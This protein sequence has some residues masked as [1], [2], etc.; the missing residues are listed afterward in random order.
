VD[1]MY[2]GLGWTWRSVPGWVFDSKLGYAGGPESWQYRAGVQFRLSEPQRVWLGVSVHDETVSRTTIGSRRS[3]SFDALLFGIDPLDYYRE[4]GYSLSLSTK[5]IDFTRL[6]LGFHDEHQTSLPVTE[7]YVMFPGHRTIRDS[8]GAIVSDTSSATLPNPPIADGQMRS[9][10]ATLSV[11]SRSFMRQKGVDYLLRSPTWTRVTLSGE[12]STPSLVA[13]DFDFGRYSLTVE[14]RQR[15]WAWGFATVTASGAITTGTVPPQRYYA[16]DFSS[17]ALALRGGGIRSLSDSNF[18]ATRAA[19]VTLRQ[20]FGRV[21]MRTGLPLLKA[22]PFTLSLLGGAY[23]TELAAPPT[24]TAVIVPTRVTLAR[25]GFQ[26]GNLTPFLGPFDFA[27][28]GSWYFSSYLPTRFQL[29][30]DL[31]P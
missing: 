17:G 1:G 29:G 27:I 22:L 2:A 11:D 14:R 26:L 7:T 3:G 25:A 9:F 19:T 6:D 15:L 4:R 28:Q 23:W 12:I 8:T 31:T 16:V 10:T 18:Q 13:T 20:D 21:F 24:D 30:F 5:L